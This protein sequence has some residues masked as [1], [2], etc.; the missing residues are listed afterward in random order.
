M[1]MLR[2]WIVSALFSA[3]LITP[4]ATQVPE[5]RLAKQF[6]MG[7]L[8]FNVMEHMGLIEKHARALGLPQVKVSWVTFNGPAAVNEALLSGSVDIASGG[9]P[10]LLV[11]WSR[12]KGTPQEVRGI[13]A[14]SSQPFLLNT[15]NPAIKTVA[16]FSDSDRIAVPAVKVSIQAIALQM[17]AAK[18]FGPANFA[19]LDSLTVSMAPPDA[20]LALLSGAGEV[21]SVFSVPPFQQQQLEKPGITTVLNSYDVMDGPHSFTVAWTSAKFREQNPVL[22]KALMAAL[23]EATDIVNADRRAAAALW[24]ADS[25]SKLPLD[26]VERVVSGSQVRWTLVPENTLKF[27]RFMQTTGMLKAAPESWRDYFFPEL[28]SAGGS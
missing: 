23:A 21:N 18:A 17:A 27:A 26:F 10:G 9:T 16:D 13:S 12:T 2:C 19:K 28:Q 25:N 14:M 22:Y 7:Y 24:I 1:N 6:S 20:T 11:L 5:I 8:Q 4:A 3:L 15:R